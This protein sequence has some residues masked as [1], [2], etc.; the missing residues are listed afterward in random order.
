M[1]RQ[2]NSSHWIPPMISI[3]EVIPRSRRLKVV[4]REREKLVNTILKWTFLKIFNSESHLKCLNVKNFP[5]IFNGWKKLGGC[6]IREFFQG[7]EKKSRE[8]KKKKGRG[9]KLV[10]FAYS[11]YSSTGV[12]WWRATVLLYVE[13]VTFELTRS[14]VSSIFSRPSKQ[15]SVFHQFP[16]KKNCHAVVRTR[17]RRE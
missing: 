17:S 4:E 12:A 11:Q 5:T 13:L 6:D 14:V 9:E 16:K 8:K 3:P 2:P 1:T 7:R 15:S 10:K